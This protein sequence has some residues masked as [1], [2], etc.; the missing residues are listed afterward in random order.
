M[1]P[2]KPK[3]TTAQPASLPE[4]KRE[5][6]RARPPEDRIEGAASSQPSNV[7]L[8]AGEAVSE[9]IV[10]RFA[11]LVASMGEINGDVADLGDVDI[12]I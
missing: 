8:S 4:P 3:S 1:D 9:E 12:E 7:P 10:S 6:E 2:I 11:T 5:A